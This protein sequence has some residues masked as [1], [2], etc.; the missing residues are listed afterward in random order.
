MKN[1]I[2]EI[3]Q[4]AASGKTGIAVVATTV[5]APA[6][7]EVLTGDATR[8]MVILLGIV[9]SLT[10]I[11]INFQTFKVRSADY[12]IK[13]RQEKIRT[14]LLEHNARESGIDPDKL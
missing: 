6:W 2:V 5:S 14:A 4:H 1:Q 11:V 12:K 10:I 3:I 13:E 9:V 8:A 7:I